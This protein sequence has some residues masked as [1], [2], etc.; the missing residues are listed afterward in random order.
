MQYPTVFRTYWEAACSQRLRRTLAEEVHPSL[1]PACPIV[2]RDGWASLMAYLRRLRL[3]R[4]ARGR[5]S[6]RTCRSPRPPAQSAGE[7]SFTP[8]SASTPSTALTTEY[9]HRKTPSPLG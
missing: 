2:R 8:A 7:T 6:S 9:R 1:F 5:W 3:E 4:M